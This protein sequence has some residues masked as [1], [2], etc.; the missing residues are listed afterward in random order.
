LASPWKGGRMVSPYQLKR[1][2]FFANLEDEFVE[3]IKKIGELK[4][5]KEGKWLFRQEEDAKFIYI[6]IEGKISLT[7][8]F[9]DHEMDRLNP[10]MQGEILGW[11][12]LV[13]PHIYTMGAIAE[14][15]S[16]VIRFD[17]KSILALVEENPEQGYILM[18]N[19]TEVIS[20]RLINRNI[21]LMSLRT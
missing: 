17:G 12:A 8:M 14:V 19:L 7:I 3:K 9:R 18:R 11:S 15:D 20:E 21:Q 13:K 4:E 16:K 10:Y 6:I 2:E 5:I 1:Y